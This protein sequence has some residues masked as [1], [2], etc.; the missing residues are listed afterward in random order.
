MLLVEFDKFFFPAEKVT[1]LENN[2]GLMVFD[3][4]T[5]HSGPAAEHHEIS[6]RSSAVL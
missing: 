3:Q 2:I 4:F 1:K 5:A 6:V